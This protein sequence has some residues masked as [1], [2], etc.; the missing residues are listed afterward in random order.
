MLMGCSLGKTT[1]RD[2]RVHSLN[3]LHVPRS[4]GIVQA[5]GLIAD[6]PYATEQEGLALSASP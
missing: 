2:I 5:P 1:T 6:H 3:S 4:D